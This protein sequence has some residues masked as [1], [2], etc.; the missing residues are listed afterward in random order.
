MQEELSEIV[1]ILA[2]STFIILLLIT[3]IIVALFISQKRKFRHRQEM[4]DLRY[5]YEQEVMKTQIETQ[6][7][8]F[9]TISQE[10]HD[11]VGS[12]V[13]MAMVHLKAGAGHASDAHG[14]LDEAMDILRDISRSINPDNIRKRGLQPSIANEL[15]RL[16][17]TRRFN[18]ELQVEGQEFTI[19]DEKQIILFRIVQEALNNVVKHSGGDAVR[20]RMQF[21]DHRMELSIED[22]GKGFVINREAGDLTR[23]SGLMNM[24]KRARLINARIEISSEVDKGT[25]VSLTYPAPDQYTTV[26][27]RL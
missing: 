24:Q 12:L 14:L 17:R 15:N 21:D 25:C 7:M 27:P 26:N 19:D 3:L 20:V 4:L 23:S 5:T 8:T 22:N 2:G 1:L 9:Q 10:L 11:N 18:T 16:K 13:S 6:L